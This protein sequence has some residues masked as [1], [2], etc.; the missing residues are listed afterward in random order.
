MSIVKG[1]NMKPGNAPVS[2]LLACFLAVACAAWAQDGQDGVADSANRIA[3]L[4]IGAQ[5][6]A[7]TVTG[8]EGASVEL[9]ERAGAQPLI[10]VF[11]RGGW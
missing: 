9:A 3:P 8:P 4:L 1:V 5:V 11:Y 10:L 2:F 7:A 6:P